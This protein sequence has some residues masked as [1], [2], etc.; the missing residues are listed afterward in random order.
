[1]GH[2]FQLGHLGFRVC[3]KWG[4]DFCGGGERMKYKREEGFGVCVLA[5]FHNVVQGI[6]LVS[7]RGGSGG[8]CFCFC[9]GFMVLLSNVGSRR[10]SRSVVIVNEM[11]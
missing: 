5:F 9:F 1:M 10:A 2:W 8:F 6:F 11:G 3:G 4:I 7:W